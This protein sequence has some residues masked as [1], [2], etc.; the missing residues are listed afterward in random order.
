MRRRVGKQGAH[1]PR[2]PFPIWLLQNNP[3]GIVAVHFRGHERCSEDLRK[4]PV[5]TDFQTEMLP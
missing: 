5:G 1:Q 2:L 4:R 3:H